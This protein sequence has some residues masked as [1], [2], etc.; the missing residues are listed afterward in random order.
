MIRTDLGDAK[1]EINN[2]DTT[3]DTVIEQATSKTTKVKKYI[4]EESM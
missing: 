1:T 3:I 2:L 4:V